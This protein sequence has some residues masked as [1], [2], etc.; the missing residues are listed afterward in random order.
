MMM[1]ITKS[2]A[3]LVLPVTVSLGSIVGS[4]DMTE[5]PAKADATNL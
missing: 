3:A 1:G 2:F 5:V 4:K